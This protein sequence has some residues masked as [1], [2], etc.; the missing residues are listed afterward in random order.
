MQSRTPMLL[1]QQN[2][3]KLHRYGVGTN[4]IDRVNDWHFTY[5][6]L[7]TLLGVV[8]LGRDFSS[9]I[10]LE[11]YGWLLSPNPGHLRV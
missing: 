9:G 2:H 4:G 3:E 8:F 11:I 1:F 5:A 10:S 7:R 6:G